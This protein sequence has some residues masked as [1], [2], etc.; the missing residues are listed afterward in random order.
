[1]IWRLTPDSYTRTPRQEDELHDWGAL[2]G[3]RSLLVIHGVFSSVEGMLS[4]LPRA[5]MEELIRR[6]D[7]RVVA[8]NHLS[9]S[10]TPEDN[11]RYFL[12]AAK[13][14]M[15]EGHFEFD[16]LAHSRGGIV[17][18][19]LAERGHELFASNCSFRKVFFV[20]SPNSGSALG[21]PQHIVD[22]V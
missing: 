11:A 22:M 1:R 2:A 4:L 10:K 19:A 7:G 6:Y 9:V 13:R 16:V 14:G 3:K 20:A 21:D 8:Y 12:E 18:R 5:A 15:P 17:A